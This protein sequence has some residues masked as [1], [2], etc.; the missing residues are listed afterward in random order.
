MFIAEANYP[1]LK[2]VKSSGKL[3]FRFHP[4]TLLDFR[5][6][7]KI[8]F[9][10]PLNFIN[11]T[12]FFLNINCS[13]KLTSVEA[14]DT[15]KYDLFECA[16]IGKYRT[17]YLSSFLLNL[18]YLLATVHLL[19]AFNVQALLLLLLLLLFLWVS[20]ICC[21]SVSRYFIISVN[22]CLGS[23]SATC[24]WLP[25]WLCYLCFQAVLACIY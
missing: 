8:T 13:M 21:V 9:L 15:N 6:S 11:C 10:G 1:F 3:Q 14:M 4:N 18:N 25:A 2:Y 23:D 17:E 16:C 7:H 19:P 12:F 24:F 5:I 20:P 22:L